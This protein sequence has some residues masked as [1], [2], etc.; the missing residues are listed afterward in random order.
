L[1]VRVRHFLALKR[2]IHIYLVEELLPHLVPVLGFFLADEG[3]LGLPKEQFLVPLQ[4][5]RRLAGDCELRTLPSHQYRVLLLHLQLL[6]FD[7]SFGAV[8]L[9]DVDAFVH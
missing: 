7:V 5:I 2:L 9:W 3:L 6:H 1:Q 8:A 4:P